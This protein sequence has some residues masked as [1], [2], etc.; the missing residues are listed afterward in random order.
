VGPSSVTED[1]N[2]GTSSVTMIALA[3]VTAR[4]ALYE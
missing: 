3:C 2:P 4:E 1:W